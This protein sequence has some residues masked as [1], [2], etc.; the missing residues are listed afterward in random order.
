MKVFIITEGG[1]NIGFGHMTRCLSLY[2]AFERIN[3]TPQL[4]TNGDTSTSGLLKDRNYLLF[5][6][7]R[8]KNKLFKK[9]INAEI[10]I[11]DSYLADLSFYEDLSKSVKIAVYID[12]TK[13]LNYP[14]GIVIN[15]TIYAKD[16]DYPRKKNISYL[17][18]TK[19]IPLRKEFWSIPKKL[20]NK[21]VNKILITFGGNDERNITPKI[22]KVLNEEHPRLTKYIVIGKGFRNIEEI[23]RMKDDKTHLIY[24]PGAEKMREL[25]LGSDIAISAGGQT[26]YELARIGVPTIGICVSDNQKGNLQGW[27]KAGFIEY[28]G[29]YRNTISLFK[30]TKTLDKL[31]PRTVRLRYS[32]IGRKL[33]DGKGVNRILQ[34]ITSKRINL[35]NKNHFLKENYNDSLKL[36]SAKENDCYDLWIWRNCPKVRKWCFDT[37]QIGYT[38]HKKWLEGKITDKNVRIYIAEN[39][40]GEKI[41]QIRFEINDKNSAYIN[42]NLNPKFFGRGFGSK[43]IRKGTELFIIENPKVRKI[44][45]E[46]MSNNTI[47]KKAF[48]KA[49]FLFSHSSFKEEKQIT[50]FKFE[51]YV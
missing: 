22:L 7:L 10:A 29:S 32:Q 43:I 45:A 17:L 13:R 39:K 11:I 37:D 49:G 25:M 33:V 44:F 41:G 24:N 19:Y 51:S 31:M 4:I 36:R 48:Q 38:A 47:S 50:I 14:R 27:Q 30:L 5:N 3:I 15:S 34:V 16:L 6:W 8:E 12:D 9:I 26:I 40:D 18:G 35:K 46:I 1:K 21:D 20:I 23:R 42:V 2:Q 28:M